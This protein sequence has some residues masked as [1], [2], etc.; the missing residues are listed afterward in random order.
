MYVG[1][2][3]VPYAETAKLMQPGQ[4]P[5]NHPA[6]DTQSAAVRS[7]AACQYRLDIQLHKGIAMRIRMVSSIALYTI[8]TAARTPAVT[9][10]R[11]NGVNE[12]QQLGYVVP[13][14]AG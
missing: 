13:V 14:R 12:R 11:W 5:F 9:G 2:A 6:I 10:D 1:P 7:T 8:R 3:L 4:S